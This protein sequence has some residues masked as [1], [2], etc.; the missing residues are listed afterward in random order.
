[1]PVR[2]GSY[3]SGLILAP[4]ASWF[5]T[6]QTRKQCSDLYLKIK[7]FTGFYLSL[8]LLHG[9]D[10]FSLVLHESVVAIDYIA[11]RFTQK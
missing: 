9:F 3:Y 6:S 10:D 2:N 8:R 4:K 11:L 1:M 5:I 7:F